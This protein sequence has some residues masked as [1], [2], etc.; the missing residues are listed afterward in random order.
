[1]G[2]AAFEAE[3]QVAEAEPDCAHGRDARMSWARLLR[4]VF[5]ADSELCPNRGGTLK[6]IGTILKPPVI[7]RRRTAAV[8]VVLSFTLRVRTADHGRDEP[9]RSSSWPP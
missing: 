7:R 4:R 2:D 5:V 9:K 1:M 6:I 3:W 8:N